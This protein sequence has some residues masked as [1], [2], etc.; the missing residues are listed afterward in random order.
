MWHSDQTILEKNFYRIDQA[1]SDA[2]MFVTRMLMLHLL[3]YLPSCSNR[4][5][6]AVNNRALFTHGVVCFRLE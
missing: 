3:R 1:T 4:V 2:K 6:L 5:N